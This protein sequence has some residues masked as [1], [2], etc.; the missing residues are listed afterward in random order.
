MGK[1]CHCMFKDVDLIQTNPTR[2]SVNSNHEDM[3]VPG[4]YVLM[5]SHFGMLLSSL[6]GDCGGFLGVLKPKVK[7][8]GFL[9]TI[10]FYFLF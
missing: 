1:E 6:S 3:Y 5:I 8:P 10:L 2:M 7:S 9:L 4:H